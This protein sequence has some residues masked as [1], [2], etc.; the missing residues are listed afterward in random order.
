[1]GT[2]ASAAALQTQGKLR[3]NLD[4]ILSVSKE[5]VIHPYS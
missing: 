2:A 3:F 1:M 4:D 5:V